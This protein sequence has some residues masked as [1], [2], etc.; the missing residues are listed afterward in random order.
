MGKAGL[1]NED[2]GEVMDKEKI[3]CPSATEVFFLWDKVV[4]V[5][6]ED[7]TEKNYDMEPLIKNEP[8]TSLENED[9]FRDVDLS[10]T[11][12][13]LFWDNGVSLDIEEIWRNGEEK[14]EE[15]I[16]CMC[17]YL[18]DIEPPHVHGFNEKGESI[19]SIEDEPKIIELSCPFGQ[20]VQVCADKIL[21]VTFSDGT[22]KTYDMK[23]LIQNEPKYFAPLEDEEFFQSVWLSPGGH[24]LIW[25]D[26]VDLAIEEVWFHGKDSA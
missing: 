24:G 21:Q 26:Y 10:P 12:R 9:I 18:K 1:Y 8:F 25:S 4:H 20:S 3:G 14:V 7:G 16:I 23:P 6:F 2:Q 17:M 22:V 13:E 5:I 11:G 19:F 15:N